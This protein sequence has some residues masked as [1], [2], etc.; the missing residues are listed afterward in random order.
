MA[1]DYRYSISISCAVCGSLTT[2]L[3]APA[4]GCY[5]RVA[6]GVFFSLCVSLSVAVFA[7]SAPICDESARHI[8]EELVKHRG[9]IVVLGEIHGTREVPELVGELACHLSEHGQVLVGLEVP[10]WL[11][12][13]I[14]AFVDGEVGSQALLADEYWQSAIQDGRQSRGMLNL[15]RRIGEVAATGRQV[16]AR[17]FDDAV[18]VFEGEPPPEHTRDELMARNVLRYRS[19]SASD[20][21]LVLVGN[22]HA[23]RSSSPGPSMAT[24]LP[25]S[26]TLTVDVR[27]LR[28]DAWNCR[29]RKC[30]VH[31][32]PSRDRTSPLLRLKT[33]SSGPY[34]ATIVLPEATA[35]PPAAGESAASRATPHLDEHRCGTI[36]VGV[37]MPGAAPKVVEQHFVIPLERQLRFADGV[38]AMTSRTGEGF[39]QVEIHL[40]PDADASKA[41]GAAV[42]RVQ[43]V[44]D[45][46]TMIELTE[47]AKCA[48]SG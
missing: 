21:V 20:F 33:I 31:A 42:R 36:T 17:G 9:R 15:L 12:E 26:E 1:V 32:L 45:P 10:R 6:R 5:V 41:V 19:E 2:R 7:E 29:D 39:G 16:V 24:L 35:S 28:G 38:E 11:T 23:R 43:S 46:A 3:Q 4:R 40:Y 8:A 30:G 14:E 13:D 27:F 44:L 34:A 48:A 18:M 25:E 37:S 47:H 22:H